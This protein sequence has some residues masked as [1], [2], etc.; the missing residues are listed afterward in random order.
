MSTEKE[1]CVRGLRLLQT[2]TH[3]LALIVG[4]VL[5]FASGMIIVDSFMHLADGQTALSIQ[6]ALFVL[7]LLELFFVVS[8]FIKYNTINVGL[9]VNVGII[10]AVKE[11]ILQ[12]DSMTWQLAI[13]FGVIFIS[14]GTLYW[15]EGHFYKDHRKEGQDLMK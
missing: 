12:L 9:I 6:D 13:A 10:A 4:I 3:Y 15:M 2:L 8:S 11:M 7:I 1:G 5:I 14:L